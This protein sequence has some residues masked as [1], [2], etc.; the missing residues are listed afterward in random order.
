MDLTRGANPVD[1]QQRTLTNS[2]T[3]KEADNHHK[4]KE[5]E[6]GGG[7]GG[8]GGHVLCEMTDHE[9]PVP[10]RNVVSGSFDSRFPPQRHPLSCSLALPLLP[11]APILSANVCIAN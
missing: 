6:G 8:G 10:C 3:N 4:N 5:R 9:G 7:G 1:D 11:H 2:K